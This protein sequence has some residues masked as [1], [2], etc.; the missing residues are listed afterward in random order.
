VYFYWPFS[1]DLLATAWQNSQEVCAERCCERDI[2]A[3]NRERPKRRRLRPEAFTSIERNRSTWIKRSQVV[4]TVHALCMA[5]VHGMLPFSLCDTALSWTVFNA[6][7]KTH[8]FSISCAR[9]VVAMQQGLYSS[10]NTQRLVVWYAERSNS[11]HACRKA[12]VNSPH[13]CMAVEMATC[14]GKREIAILDSCG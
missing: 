3:H 1:V 13:A 6:H 4:S 7:L 2:T 8:L 11:I 14:L 9:R 10:N 5:R 12:I